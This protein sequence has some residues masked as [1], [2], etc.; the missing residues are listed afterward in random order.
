MRLEDIPA[1]RIAD[2]VSRAVAEAVREGGDP[3]AIVG[4]A[5]TR[6]QRDL[7]V[8]GAEETPASQPTPTDDDVPTPSLLPSSNGSGPRQVV[9]EDDVIAARAAGRNEL[10]LRAGAIVTPLARDAAH[11]KGVRLVEGG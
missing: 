8:G 5:L 6:A 4:R 3:E 10:D 2:V 9:T 7:G 1:E 11:D